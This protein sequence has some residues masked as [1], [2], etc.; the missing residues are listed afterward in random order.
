MPLLLKVKT[1]TLV[2]ALAASPLTWAQSAGSSNAARCQDLQKEIQSE[3]QKSVESRLPRIDPGTYNQK[4]ADIR[5]ILSQ[6]VTSGLSK[7]LSLDFSSLL[8][9]LIDK[10]LDKA[11]QTA[12]QTFQSRMNDVLQRYG[13]KGGSYEQLGPFS[14]AP[15][16]SLGSG[17]SKTSG[18][19]S[20]SPYKQPGGKP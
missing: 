18:G 9:S 16:G 15:V 19:T 4:A 1:A 5:G 13:I 17:V 12:S 3:F 10:G 8:K 7:L 14:G 2:L 20:G 11:S 6:D